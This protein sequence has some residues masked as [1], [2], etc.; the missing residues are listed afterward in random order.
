MGDLF[1]SA[2]SNSD[3]IPSNDQIIKKFERKQ[4]QPNLRYYHAICSEG[5]RKT[6]RTSDSIVSIC[7]K[8]WTPDL[9]NIKQECQLPDCDSVYTATEGTTKEKLEI[10]AVIESPKECKITCERQKI[11]RKMSR[12]MERSCLIISIWGVWPWIVY[13]QWH[14]REQSLCATGLTFSA[15]AK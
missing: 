9:P 7:A 10:S 2:T 14:D 15:G 8:L 4:S 1:N 5:A 13:W 11:C 12:N 3:Y 6:T